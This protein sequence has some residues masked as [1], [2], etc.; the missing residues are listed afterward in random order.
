MSKQ[1]M[2][3]HVLSH[4]G[5]MFIIPITDSLKLPAVKS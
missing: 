5:L 2:F 4:V 3:I 1:H